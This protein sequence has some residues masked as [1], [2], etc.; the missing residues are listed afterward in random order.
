M[1]FSKIALLAAL[2]MIG[3]GLTAHARD[4][5]H[6]LAGKRA[7]PMHMAGFGADLPLARIV[8]RLDLS[9]AQ[10]QSLSSLLEATKA[11][12]QELRKQQRELLE[13]SLKTL[14]DDP[15]YPALIE[16]RKQLAIAAI[17][18]RSDLNIQIYALLTP[19]QKAQVPALIEEM[20]T[21]AK[22]RRMKRWTRRPA[23][24]R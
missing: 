12:S 10:R 20:K 22:E 4:V 19:E 21:N 18:Q 24:A 16:K 1:K 2:F 9:D 11:Q 8:Q 13:A 6:E 23:V 7:R 15:D 5:G 14:P 3:T 17:Q